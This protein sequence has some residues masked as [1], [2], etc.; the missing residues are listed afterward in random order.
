MLVSLGG[1]A[2]PEARKAAVEFLRTAP[3]PFSA[4]MHTMVCGPA[5][6]AQSSINM[7]WSGTDR[8]VIRTNQLHR[9]YLL[10]AVDDPNDGQHHG[11]FDEDANHRR[12]SRP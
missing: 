8:A 12:Q 9:S 7:L 6:F 4:Q 2:P 3:G 5:N 10:A 11:H 1:L